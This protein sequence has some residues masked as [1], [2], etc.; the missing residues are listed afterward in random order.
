MGENS[1][2]E[3]AA[4]YKIWE[5]LNEKNG[6]RSRRSHVVLVGTIKLFKLADKHDLPHEIKP[7]DFNEE[8]WAGELKAFARE[9]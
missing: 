6:P 9:E 5:T 4:I 8:R 2:F 7:D 3:L 1:P